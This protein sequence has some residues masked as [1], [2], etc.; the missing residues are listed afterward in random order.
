MDNSKKTFIFSSETLKVLSLA[1][2]ISISCRFPSITD[3]AGFVALNSL[4]DSPLNKRL[5]SMKVDK[6]II[7]T[8][9][10][11]ILNENRLLCNL[12]KPFKTIKLNSSATTYNLSEQMYSVILKAQQIAK[13]YY[14]T[15]V[16]GCNELLAAFSECIPNVYE[17]FLKKCSIYPKPNNQIFKEDTN[18]KIPSDISGC[19][20]ILNSKFSSDE[21]TCRILGRDKE[22]LELVRILAKD[23]KRNAILVGD[24]GVGKTALVEKF[25]WM[26]VTGNCPSKFKDCTIVSLDIN[27]IVAG[28]HYR[29]SA[30]ARFNSLIKFL[31]NYPNCILFIDEVHN[32]LGAGACR[33]GDLDLANALKPLLARGETRVIGATTTLEYNKY[34]SKDAALKRRFEKVLVKE[35][36]MHEIYPMIKNQIE[37]LSISHN[38]SISEEVVYDVIFYASCFNKETKNPDRTLDLIDRAMATA[39]LAGKKSVTREDV[40]DNFNLNYEI[41]ENTPYNIKVGLAFHEAGHCL[42][43]RFSDELYNFKTTALSIM[44]AENY[45][46]AH[47]L[48]I[49]DNIIPSSTLKYYIQLIGCKLAGRVAEQMYT[50]D[51]SAGASGDMSKATQLAKEV[52]TKYG[53]IQTFS[54]NRVYPLEEND[55]LLTKDKFA[56]IDSEIDFILEKARMYAKYILLKYEEELELLVDALLSKKMLSGTEIDEI[57]NSKN[58]VIQHNCIVDTSI[59]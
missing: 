17:I 23:T 16:I 55:S 13:E 58:E 43:H 11:E 49:D 4:S 30:E 39:E 29:G 21:E 27:S 6:S 32:L 51:L 14:S 5:T 45:Y 35:P 47:V 48:E 56:Q 25:A 19:L 57:L 59:M 9:C 36:K 33:D 2:R 24:Q 50:S 53:L 12:Q 28:T 15:N 52:V 40:L 22:T 3:L 18:M 54:V 34:F 20:T 10:T 46:G 38:T 44:P 7:K 41:L 37:R 8:A 1:H 31:E 26:I 42:V